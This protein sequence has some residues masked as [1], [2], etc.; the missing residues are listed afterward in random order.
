MS[1]IIFLSDNRITIVINVIRAQYEQPESIRGRYG[2]TDTRNAA[3]GSDSA[4]S[5]IREIKIY[6]PEFKVDEWMK[7]EEIFF[8]KG[9]VDFD[10]KEYV[11]KIR[12]VQ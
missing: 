11:H 3:H 8:K 6:F 2:L 9:Q 5:A 4:D 12:S 1:S 7:S 10:P